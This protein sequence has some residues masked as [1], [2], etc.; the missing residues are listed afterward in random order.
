[1]YYIGLV[2]IFF[3]NIVFLVDACT[4]GSMLIVEFNSVTK[5]IKTFGVH[6]KSSTGMLLETLDWSQAPFIV[7]IHMQNWKHFLN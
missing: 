2:S 1:M 4:W 3:S 5:V 7:P 6:N